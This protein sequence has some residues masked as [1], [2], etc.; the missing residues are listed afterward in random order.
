MKT[1][2]IAV[3]KLKKITSL[4][5][6]PFG[7]DYTDHMLQATYENGKW[8]E[9]QI[10]PYGTLEL[11]PSTSALHYG[12]AI[13]EGMKAF[14]NRHNDKV[15]IFRLNEHFERM[16]R[17]AERLQ[18]PTIPKEIFVEGL[19]AFVALE[20]NWVPDFAGH[21][22]YLR[23]FMFADD[24]FLGVRPSNSY[25]FLIIA[26]PASAYYSR[27][28]KVLVESSYSR[29]ASG[30]VGNVKAAGNYAASL[31][32]TQLASKQ[33]YDQVL[34]TDAEKHE[35]VQEVGTMNIFFVFKNKV[36]TPTT[37]NGTILQ[38][39]TRKSIIHL[40]KQKD[41]TVEEGNISMNTIIE[42]Y[43]NGQLLEVFGTGTA[44]VINLVSELKYKN[45]LIKLNEMPNSLSAELK[46]MLTDIRYGNVEDTNNWM[47]W[48]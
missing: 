34:W 4:E 23:P 45:E 2:L 5:N 41:I 28:I 13:F 16:N 33:G 10:M 8:G 1:T 26:S 21:S 20:R 46:T 37:D 24:I 40:L 17:S 27:P 9:A 42:G 47:T 30:G 11:F 22:L 15:G 6:V 7:S 3:S 48:V 29:A 25:R 12:Q 44:V 14:K 36:L 35:E 38:G 18:M 31:F 32:P 43:K 39:V 19:K